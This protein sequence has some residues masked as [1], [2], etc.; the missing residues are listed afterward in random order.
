[1]KAEAVPLGSRLLEQ[2]SDLDRDFANHTI[3]PDSLKA[4][5]AA[6][7]QTQGILRA[8]HLKYHLLA[9]EV[10]TPPQT[11]TYAELRGY[12]SGHRH[13]HH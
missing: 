8:T 11:M 2:E 10:L 5:T 4:S 9:A 3:T 6:I 7:A 1:M 12:G 13:D